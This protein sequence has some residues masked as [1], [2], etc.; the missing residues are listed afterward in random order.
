MRRVAPCSLGPC[1]QQRISA[2]RQTIERSSG[3]AG[4]NRYRMDQEAKHSTNRYRLLGLLTQIQDC[5]CCYL[6]RLAEGSLSWG[7]IL[8]FRNLEWWFRRP[9]RDERSQTCYR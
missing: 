1:R 2:K 7:A 8:A 6:L 5:N 9:H 3:W 4:R